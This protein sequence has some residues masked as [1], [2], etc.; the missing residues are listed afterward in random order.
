ME[1]LFKRNHCASII[2]SLQPPKWPKRV[3]LT[4]AKLSPN[5]SY[6][7]AMRS[8]VRSV[9]WIIS[10]GRHGNKLPCSRQRISQFTLRLKNRAQQ[11][12]R[13]CANYTRCTPITC[14]WTIPDNVILVRKNKVA[15]A[16]IFPSYGH[17][18]PQAAGRSLNDNAAVLDYPFL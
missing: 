7:S 16:N 17:S 10:A 3:F 4:S 18:T 11:W 8:F 9:A 1:R 15:N 2:T 14:I 13:K 6:V 12:T 5:R